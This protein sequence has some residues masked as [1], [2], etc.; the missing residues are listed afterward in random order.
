MVSKVDL[1]LNY[2][3]YERDLVKFVDYII[4]KRIALGRPTTITN[5]AHWDLIIF[6]LR[7]WYA[8]FPEYAGQFFKHMKEVR[9]R[10]KHLGVSREGEAMLQHLVEVPQSLYQM[11]DIAFPDQKWDKKFI[12]KF[13]KRIPALAG[14]DKL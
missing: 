13:A 11:I 3:P 2:V 5:E 1:K 10:A 9:L 14:A 6:I 7:G 8:L 12:L 4:D